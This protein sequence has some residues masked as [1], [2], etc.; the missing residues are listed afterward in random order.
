MELLRIFKI[1]GHVIN[2][3][4][5]LD[6]FLKDFSLIPGKKI[7]V[8]GGGKIANEISAKL[9]IKPIIVEGRRITDTPSLHVI[10]MV[11]G[12]LLNKLIVGKLNGMEQK[13]I[14]LT[15]ADAILYPGKKRPT[16][17]IDYGHVAD[18]ES[19][20]VN[21]SFISQLIEL[22]MIPVLSPV[23][24]DLDGNLLNINADTVAATIA[25][26][27]SSTYKTEL[28]LCFEKQGVMEDPDKSTSVIREI[29]TSMIQTLIESNIIRDGMIPKVQNARDAIRKGVSKVVIC[30]S[31]EIQQLITSELST[32]TTIY[33]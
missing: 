5:Y 6:M 11:Y 23:T 2:E 18:L 1:G 10:T 16:G 8:H 4:A 19:S 30:K 13:S 28:I 33:A 14:G 20:E 7:I 27:L 9:G 3:P 21:T 25:S 22:G 12:G 15:G 17:E 31:S 24:A 32:G 26:S 29:H